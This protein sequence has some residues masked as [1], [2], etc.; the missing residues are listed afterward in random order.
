MKISCEAEI[1]H[2]FLISLGFCPSLSIALHTPHEEHSFFTFQFELLSCIPSPL[3]EN[4]QLKR[5]QRKPIPKKLYVWLLNHWMYSP[6]SS[7]KRQNRCSG[8]IFALPNLHPPRFDIQKII[9]KKTQQSKAFL[10]CCF[11][12]E[13][14]IRKIVSQ[15]KKISKKINREDKK[16]LL[17]AESNI[18]EEYFFIRR[19]ENYVPF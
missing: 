4:K 7:R 18:D 3:K 2:F 15:I 14:T 16:S 8:L 1:L 9:K 6:M 12:A 13:K 5:V 19:K 17:F 10:L 11:R